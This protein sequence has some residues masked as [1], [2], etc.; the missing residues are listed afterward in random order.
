MSAT[1][2]RVMVTSIS[3][4]PG[5]FGAFYAHRVTPTLT[6]PVQPRGRAVP[7]DRVD[8]SAAGRQQ[9]TESTAEPAE[10]QGAAQS[11]KTGAPP[12]A[13]QERDTTARRALDSL[14]QRDQEV[15]LHEQAHLLAAGPYAKGAPSY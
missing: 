6:A 15:R 10:E 13:P 4:S 9:A 5:A 11:G 8:I 7:Q 2:D 1:L 12:G 3:G 14:R